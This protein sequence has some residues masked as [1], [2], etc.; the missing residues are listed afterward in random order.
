MAHT[1]GG[2]DMLRDAMAISPDPL[3]GAL[4]YFR[5]SVRTYSTTN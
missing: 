4:V 2:D 3:P 1:V 5:V